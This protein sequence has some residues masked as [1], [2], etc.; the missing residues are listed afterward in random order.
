MEFEKLEALNALSDDSAGEQPELYR[1]ITW[2]EEDGHL[3]Y[4]RLINVDAAST[5]GDM[6]GNALAGMMFGNSKFVFTTHFP[7]KVQT[8][9]A[10]QI[11]QENNAVTWEVPMSQLMSGT[12][13]M[14]ATVKKPGGAV[15]LWI[16][17]G[18]VLVLVV[19]AVAGILVI[20]PKRRAE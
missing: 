8:A 5:G 14:R 20:G 16:G 6:M 4:D 19:L 17:L 12:V 2:Q 15:L 1:Q 9:N 11:D 7:G 13:E 18:I 3:R 10:D